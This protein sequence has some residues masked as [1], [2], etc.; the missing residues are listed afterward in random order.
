MR[1]VNLDVQTL[2]QVLDFVNLLEVQISWRAQCFG[3]LEVRIS[4][5]STHVCEEVHE[6]TQYEHTCVRGSQIAALATKFALESS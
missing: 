1:D 5:E 3:N 4:R 2:R 6:S